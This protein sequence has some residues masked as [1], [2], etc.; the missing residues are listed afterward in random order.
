[1]PQDF[2]LKK[3]EKGTKHS[4]KKEY[5]LAKI[6][7]GLGWKANPVNQKDEFDLDVSAFLVS[8]NGIIE[9]RFNFVYYGSENREEPFDKAKFPTKRKWIF[10]T[11]PK[12][13]NGA[14]LGPNDN[15]I[16]GDGDV[17]TMNVNLDDLDPSIEEIIITVT[18][19]EAEERNQNFGMVEDAYI[20]IY[21]DS[22]VIKRGLFRYDL[23]HTF[24]SETGVEIGRL[25][26][27]QNGEEWT[28]ETVGKGYEG[29]LQTF[30]NM[31]T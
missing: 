23:N 1:M 8:G 18:I 9:D 31:Y 16:G 2:E 17:E 28:F 14:L 30:I 29:G 22:K 19:H 27:N 3:I 6:G 7:I 11:R 25:V 20:W 15:V 24:S 26:R 4:I 10:E 21:D 12:S 13:A 5:G